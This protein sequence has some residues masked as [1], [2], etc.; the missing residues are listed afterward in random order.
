LSESEQ[1]VAELLI[2]WQVFDIVSQAVTST[3]DALT[4]NFCSTSSVACSN[5]RQIRAKSNNP[6]LS[7]W[8][9]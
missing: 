3:C 8:R 6:R 5:I 2:I 9:Y 1:S 4:L 7:Y